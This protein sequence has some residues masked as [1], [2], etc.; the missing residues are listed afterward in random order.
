MQLRIDGGEVPEDEAEY[1]K[2]RISTKL[3]TMI[4]RYGITEGQHCK[5]CKHVVYRRRSKT[6]IKCDLWV[7][8]SSA[9]SDIRLNQACGKWEEECYKLNK[10]ELTQSGT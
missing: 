1:V 7:M 5:N 8:S 10:L 4:E 9:S 3:V 6:Y 2:P